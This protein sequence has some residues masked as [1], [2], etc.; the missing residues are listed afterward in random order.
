M[1]FFITASLPEHIPAELNPRKMFRRKLEEQLANLSQQSEE[2][3]PAE[4][5]SYCIGME[6]YDGAEMDDEDSDDD[7]VSNYSA[8][9]ERLLLS[10]QSV[11]ST[12]NRIAKFHIHS[13]T[14]F[15]VK[16]DFETMRE[17]IATMD[18]GVW[19]SG[20]DVQAVQN[21]SKVVRYITKLDTKPYSNM[22][23]ST[24]A[25]SYLIYMWA[26]DN[27]M[28]PFDPLD[29]FVVKHLRSSTFL[30]SYLSAFAR[31][32]QA[33]S[34]P[35]LEPVQV[36]FNCP[37]TIEVTQWYNRKL[38]NF[39]HKDPQLYL[40][41]DSNVGKSYFV[42]NILVGSDR[43]LRIYYPERSKWAFSSLD[44][45]FHEIIL[46][47][48]ADFSNICHGIFKRLLEG[49]SFSAEVKYGNPNVIAWKKPIIFVSNYP[50]QHY[51]IDQ[52]LMN[53]LHVVHATE[54]YY[55]NYTRCYTMNISAG[56]Q[57]TSSVDSDFTQHNASG[58]SGINSVDDS[59]SV[60]TSSH[61][62]VSFDN[63]P[64]ELTRLRPNLRRH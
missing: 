13:Y 33:S 23:K 42:Q 50:P 26:A 34:L 64:V 19:S 9:G 36:T 54:P 1:Q 43:T 45:G 56:A 55:I 22:S 59:L 3:R 62:S 57:Q 31:K 14:Q 39:R 7:Y 5:T 27:Y 10:Q 48:E 11:S 40:W 20:L 63:Y 60:S 51:A 25:F 24:F 21:K 37:W 58:S 18:G 61:S 35:P 4:I 49:S 29:P 38:L 17:T 6:P 52:A 8:S 28:N 53:R 32:I 30:Q 47:E 44:M 46:F 2:N 16:V 12:Q 15:N 41:G